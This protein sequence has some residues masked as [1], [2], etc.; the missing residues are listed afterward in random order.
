MSDVDSQGKFNSSATIPV[1][2]KLSNLP[3]DLAA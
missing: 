3:F 2:T 1:V